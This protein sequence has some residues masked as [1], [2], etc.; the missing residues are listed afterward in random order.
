M[1]IR[2]TSIV[3]NAA[4]RSSNIRETFF[5]SWRAF[6]ILD[7]VQSIV[8]SVRTMERACTQ[9]E[10]SKAKNGTASMIGDIALHCRDIAFHCFTYK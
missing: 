10:Y 4:E 9:I 8:V 7:L 3:L 2:L 5:L 1:Y 6:K